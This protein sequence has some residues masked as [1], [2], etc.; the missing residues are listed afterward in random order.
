M[1]Q[2]AIQEKKLNQALE[3]LGSAEINNFEHQF[4][5][6]NQMG[7]RECADLLPFGALDTKMEEIS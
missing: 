5:N 1:K 3:P 4:A 6:E 2:C 7:Q